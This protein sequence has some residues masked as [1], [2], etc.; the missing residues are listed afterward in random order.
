MISFAGSLFKPP[1]R[2]LSFYSPEFVWDAF[3]DQMQ[4]KAQDKLNV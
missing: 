4:P 2:Q 1:R 3:W